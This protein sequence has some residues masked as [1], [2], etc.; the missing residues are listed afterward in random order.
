[1]DRAPLPRGVALKYHSI[2]YAEQSRLQAPSI[3]GKVYRRVFL[4]IR[5]KAGNRRPCRRYLLDLG[6]AAVA[7][8]K[9]PEAVAA[10]RKVVFGASAVKALHRPGRVR[11]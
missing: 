8:P 1:M 2:I 6:G 10:Y 4:T 7:A 3:N 9:T 5:S 11:C